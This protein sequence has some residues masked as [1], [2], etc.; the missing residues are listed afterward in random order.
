MI[1]RLVIALVW[2]VG[3]TLG[4]I[5][6]GTILVSFGAGLEIMA[7]IGGFLKTYAAL[8]G[9]LAGLVSFFGPSIRSL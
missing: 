5:L 4:C 9:L 6:L 2:A 8:L 7:V 3:V 1:S